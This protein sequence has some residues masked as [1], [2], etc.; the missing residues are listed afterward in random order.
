MKDKSL[1]LFREDFYN[2]QVSILKLF[3][4]SVCK[5]VGIR[6]LKLFGGLMVVKGLCTALWLYDKENKF[7][8][9]HRQ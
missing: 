5:T 3:C 4:P 8:C 7:S 9:C 1:K 2:E 6:F